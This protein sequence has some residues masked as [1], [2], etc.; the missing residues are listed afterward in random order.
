MFS[1]DTYLAVYSWPRGEAPY[2]APLLFRDDGCTWGGLTA[3]GM[4]EVQRM[5]GRN[6]FDLRGIVVFVVDFV[7]LLGCR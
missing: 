3:K 4:G 6:C 7:L 5:V 2:P 1:S